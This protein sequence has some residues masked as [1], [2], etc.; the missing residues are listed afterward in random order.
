VGVVGVYK[1]VNEASTSIPATESAR[2]SATER[3]QRAATET[4]AVHATSTASTSR[5]NAVQ[6]V[7]A[8]MAA[9]AAARSLWP[10]VFFDPFDTFTQ[11]G[12][13]SANETDS[14]ATVNYS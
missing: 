4:Q 12:W 13:P 8:A 14:Y 10:E 9:T 5:A 2:S 7:E 3:A 11:G 6:Q 1:W